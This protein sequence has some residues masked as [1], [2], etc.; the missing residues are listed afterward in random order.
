MGNIYSYSY[1][2]IVTRWS[3]DKAEMLKWAIQFLDLRIKDGDFPVRYLSLPEGRTI[4]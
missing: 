1:S 4:H 3:F 2:I